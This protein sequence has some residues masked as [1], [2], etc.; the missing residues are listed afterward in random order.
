MQVATKRPLP[1]STR[2]K[3][4]RRTGKRT[5]VGIGVTPSRRIPKPELKAVDTMFDMYFGNENSLS[6]K[7]VNFNNVNKG[8]GSWNRI[9]RSAQMK[10]IHLR[11]IVYSTDSV[12]PPNDFLHIFILYSDEECPTIYS[13]IFNG[14]NY[15]GSLTST[16]GN[17]TF[18]HNNLDKNQNYRILYS[19]HIRI[20]DFSDLTDNGN[21]TESG[22]LVDVHIP[23][24]F[25]TIWDNVAYSTFDGAITSGNLL[26]GIQGTTVPLANQNLKFQG[27]VRVR[28][29]DV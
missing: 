4:K 23:V 18:S 22:M 11:G 13:Q 20:T 10:S 19:K 24:D 7:I 1:S 9:G 3:K 21:S 29:T 2:P 5:F 12:I 14:Y 28:F 27:S 25:T 17:R 8:T 26:L 6:N 15:L 16:T